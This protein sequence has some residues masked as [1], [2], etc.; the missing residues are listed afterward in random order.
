M[1]KNKKPD[2]NTIRLHVT[3]DGA[4]GGK[5]FHIS[6]GEL[7]RHRVNTEGHTILSKDQASLLIVAMVNAVLPSIDKV[8]AMTD[9]EIDQVLA[10]PDSQRVMPKDVSN[11]LN[12]EIAREAA[13]NTP[14][15]IRPP[16]FQS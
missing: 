10:M 1:S 7:L 4:K 15:I 6:T 14:R 9:E 16:G 2:Y 12:R 8:A 13:R 11:E 3:I 5:P